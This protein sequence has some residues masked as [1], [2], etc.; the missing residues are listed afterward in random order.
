MKL[1][2][3]FRLFLSYVALNFHPKNCLNFY[4]YL[5][6]IVVFLV[7]DFIS[8][9]NTGNIENMFTISRFSLYLVTCFLLLAGSSYQAI[10]QQDPGLYK[11]GDNVD[12]LN[13]DNFKESIYN[14]DQGVFLEFY[15]H[16]CGACNLHGSFIS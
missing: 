2:K 4:S 14:I 3:Y 11:P 1:F 6:K 8:T 7:L 5:L 13:V 10:T 15:S 12:I 16:W 9:V